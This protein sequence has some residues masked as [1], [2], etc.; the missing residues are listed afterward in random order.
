[1]RRPRSKF[2]YDP[3]LAAFVKSCIEARLIYSVIR[4][5][6]IEKFGLDRA[7]S[8]SAISRFYQTLPDGPG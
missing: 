5:K 2:Y 8:V 3:E 7:P 6:C 1:M 4:A